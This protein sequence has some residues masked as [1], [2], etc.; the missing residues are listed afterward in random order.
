FIGSEEF[1]KKYPSI[2]K[3]VV[4]VLVQSAKWVSDQE[5]SPTQVYQLWTKSGVR[6]SDWREDFKEQNLKELA[7]PLLD[8]YFVTQYEG[9]VAQAKK[10]G[11]IRNTFDVK[12]WLEPRFLNEVLKELGLQDYWKPADRDGRV[13]SAVT[14]PDARS[15]ALTP[16]AVAAP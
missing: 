12:S 11:L 6:Y 8:T 14:T 5:K 7:S 1:I 3:R 2:T 13:G 15:A 4:K 16:A 10:F 9:Q